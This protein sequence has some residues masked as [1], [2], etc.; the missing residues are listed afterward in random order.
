[1]QDGPGP[2]PVAPTGRPNARD[3]EFQALTI[4]PGDWAVDFRRPIATL[5]GS[6]VAVCLHDPQLGLGGMNH[7]L[8]P[9]RRLFTN[10]EDVT[11]AGDYAMEVL[12]NAM[13]S[14]GAQKSRLVA[15][16][17]G[18]GNVVAAIDLAI[19][20]CN[21]AFAAEWL[22]REGIPLQASDFGGPWSRKVICVPQ[23]GDVYCRRTPVTL[24]ADVARQEAA[25]ERLLSRFAGDRGELF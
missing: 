10:E 15:K 1:M 6:C 4:H 23:T 8:L 5:L 7:F 22:K 9:S 21:A 20:N 2:H 19:G 18:G 11:L 25:Y 16:A 3:Y 14:K 17:F 12:V 24:A 13:L